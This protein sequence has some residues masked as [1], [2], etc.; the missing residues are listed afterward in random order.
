MLAVLG[1]RLSGEGID[2]GKASGLGHINLPIRTSKTEQSLDLL[3][4]GASV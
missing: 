2:C 3:R 1:V 4:S